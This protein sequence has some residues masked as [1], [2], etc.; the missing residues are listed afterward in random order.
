MTVILARELLDTAKTG[1]VM[2]ECGGI[3]TSRAVLTGDG[4]V[5]GGPLLLIPAVKDANP[6]GGWFA[7]VKWKVLSEEVKFWTST[8]KVR[9]RVALRGFKVCG[10]DTS[11]PC[12]M[13]LA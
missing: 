10:E 9:C 8:T 6:P 12:V 2:P 11:S 13:R 7:I 3:S 4:G 1:R 5:T